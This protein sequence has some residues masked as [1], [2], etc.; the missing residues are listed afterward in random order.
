MKTNLVTKSETKTINKLANSFNTAHQQSASGILKMCQ[1]A[2]EARKMEKELFSLFCKRTSLGNK[3]T[4]SKLA[5]IGEKYDFLMKN[6]N[7]LPNHWTTIYNLSL[8]SEEDFLEN[9][10]LTLI[11]P[12]MSGNESLSLIGKGPNKKKYTPKKIENVESGFG[13]YFYCESIEKAK[14]LEA[15]IKLG[16]D[17][18]IDSQIN[19]KLISFLNNDDLLEAA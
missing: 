2:Y 10:E 14:D 1:I 13:V 5:T 9:A 18:H 3:S 19:G 6:V 16:K 12:A 4:I 15:L 8:L 7:L 17:L 11:N